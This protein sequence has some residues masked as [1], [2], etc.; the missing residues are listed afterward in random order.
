MAHPKVRADG[1][2][3]SLMHIACAVTVVV[4]VYILAGFVGDAAVAATR[5]MSG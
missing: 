5:Y 2:V 3:E 4:V 1:V